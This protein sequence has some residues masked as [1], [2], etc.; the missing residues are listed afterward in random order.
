[1]SQTPLPYRPHNHRACVDQAL[2]DAHRICNDAKARLTPTR[3]RVLELIWQSHKPLG[4]Y[5]L[6]GAL[7]QDGH[8]AAPPTV[9]RALD[10]LQQHGLV[11]RIA[12]LNAFVGCAHAGHRHTGFFLICRA[13]RNVLELSAPHVAEAV[14]QAAQ[15]E[16]FAAEDTTLEIAGLC[17]ACQQEGGH[18]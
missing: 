2:A 16:G 13:C 15:D 1:M 5:D 6:L 14:D 11:H 4:A 3:E 10:F 9:Y 17:P 7:A 8:N 12:S 18:E